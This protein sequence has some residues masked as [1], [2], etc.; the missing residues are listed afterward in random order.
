MVFSDT[1]QVED[2]LI[3]L[4]EDITGLGSGGISGNTTLLK[5]FTRNINGS[6]V[7]FFALAF[8]YDTYWNLDDR[9][10]GDL[11]VASTNLV[12]GQ[13]DYLFATELLAVNQAFVKD[14]SG[15]FHELQPQ[16]D[17][18]EPNTFTLVNGSGVPKTYKLVGNSILLDP[19]PSYNST[20]GLKVVFKR[21][22]DKFTYTDGAVTPGIPSLFHPFL[23]R[24]ACLPWLIDKNRASK[25]DIYN[26]IQEDKENIK[27]FMAN[28]GRPRRFSLSV[29]KED[30]R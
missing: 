12:S 3:Q 22:A 25:R 13:Q 15:V 30:N 14:Q 27:K 6:L 9:N 19:V 16:D 10:H 24:D 21:N 2:G 11:P 26:L 8:E 5:R 20:L 28:R 1:T 23:A 7:R 4:C 17:K 29:R 18:S